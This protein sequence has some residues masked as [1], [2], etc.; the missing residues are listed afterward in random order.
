MLSIK[1]ITDCG[2]ITDCTLPASK[3]S[4]LAAAGFTLDATELALA[5]EVL[6]AVA[7]VAVVLAALVLVALDF[8]AV[9]FLAATGFFAAEAADVFFVAEVFFT[10]VLDDADFADAVFSV[11]S[12]FFTILYP[13]FHK[14]QF[15][16]VD[17]HT[18]S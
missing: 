9:V 18:N 3:V 14:T 6:E 7:L 10:A 17:K 1:G 5:A 11:I 8:A 13:D 12:L 2:D 15:Y 4:A 16:L